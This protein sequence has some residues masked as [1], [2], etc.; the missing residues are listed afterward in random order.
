MVQQF[1]NITGTWIPRDRNIE[2]DALSK[3]AIE[4][5]PW[6]EDIALVDQDRS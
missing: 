3:A 1:S 4:T 6:P 2:A 5:D